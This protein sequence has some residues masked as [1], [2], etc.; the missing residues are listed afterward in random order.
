MTE[1]HIITA[2]VITSGEKG[3]GSELPK[4]LEISWENGIDVEAVIGDEAYFG[5]VNLKIVVNKTL[6]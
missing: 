6:K 3:D 5:K 1:E 4:F 2:A